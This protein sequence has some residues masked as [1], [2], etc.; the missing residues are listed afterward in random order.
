MIVLVTLLMT[1]EGR[2]WKITI[3]PEGSYQVYGPIENSGHER[4]MTKG[5]LGFGLSLPGLERKMIEIINEYLKNI[6]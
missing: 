4:L 2:C 1:V 5:R 3:D 6:K